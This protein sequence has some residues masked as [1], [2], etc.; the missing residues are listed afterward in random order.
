LYINGACD[1]RI[2]TNLSTVLKKNELLS[3]NYPTSSK[4]YARTTFA[5]KSAADMNYSRPYFISMA[6]RTEP[7][8]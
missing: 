4:K 8:P 3:E 2:G 5:I 1:T 7:T 6:V